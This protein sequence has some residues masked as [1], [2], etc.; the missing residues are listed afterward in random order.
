MGNSAAAV[1]AQQVYNSTFK[2]LIN[3]DFS[4]ATDI[5]RYQGVLEHALLKVDFSVGMGTYM[6]PS[7]LNLN[8]E[9][10]KGHKN[11]TLVSST[12]MKIGSNGGINKDHK[13]LPSP[14]S[15]KVGGVGHEKE[16]GT[17]EP[18]K[19]RLATQHENLK[20]LTEKHNDD[21]VY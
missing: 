16:K 5:E 17:Y 18:A 15:I 8:I 12:E 21:K 6:L 7:D 20:M 13:K 11:K 3:E 1:D 9:K 19:D 2:A 10:T 4:I 14:V